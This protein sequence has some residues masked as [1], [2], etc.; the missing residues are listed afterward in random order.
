MRSLPGADQYDE[1]LDHPAVSALTSIHGG[2][3]L[4]L[5]FINNCKNSRVVLKQVPRP[6]KSSLAS[7]LFVP[8]SRHVL[9]NIVF[10]NKRVLNYIML[11]RHLLSGSFRCLPD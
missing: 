2:F 6:P 11:T 4:R 7:Q 10:M 3:E 5:I 8:L 9:E 1:Y